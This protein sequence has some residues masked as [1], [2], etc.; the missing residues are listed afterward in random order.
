MLVPWY[1]GAR[2]RTIPLAR[3]VGSVMEVLMAERIRMIID[4]DEELRLAVKLAANKAGVS[5]SE[6]VNQVLRERLVQELRDARKY[7]PP[8]GKAD[9]GGGV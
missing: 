6:F 1:T 3:K 8:K 9:D 2:G 7:L 4:T 5:A